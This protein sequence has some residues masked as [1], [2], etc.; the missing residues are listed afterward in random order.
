MTDHLSARYELSTDA[1]ITFV[2]C[3]YKEPRSTTTYIRLA[4]K[5]LCRTMQSL[6]QELLE[7]Y[8]LHDGNDSQPK[9]KELKAVFLEI[10]RQVGRILFVRCIR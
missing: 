9:S 1:G 4:L 8:K 2:Y 7:L 5:Q 10:R 3:N 6:P